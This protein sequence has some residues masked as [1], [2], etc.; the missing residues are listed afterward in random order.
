MIEHRPNC[1]VAPALRLRLVFLLSLVPVPPAAGAAEAVPMREH[2]RPGYQYHVSCRVDISGSLSLP[3]DKGQAAPK[4]LTVAGGSAIEYDE[5]ILQQDRD[6]VVK[7]TARLYRR[8]DFK[9]RVGDKLQESTIRPEVRRLVVLRHNNIEVPFSPDGPLLWGEMD[10]V[11]TD[12][13]TPALAGLFATQAVRP[14]AAWPA[15]RSAIQELTDMERIK[16]GSVTC[17]FEEFTTLSG[18]RHAR[19]G[20]R[21]TV[22]GVN[23]DGPNRQQLDGYFFFDLETNHLSYLYLKGTQFLL[24][25]D[26]KTQGKVVGHFTLTRQLNPH[27]RELSD[28]GLR[29]VKLDPDADNTLMLYDNPEIGV[30]FLF[31]RRWRVA[32][33]RGLQVAL[34]EINGNGLL[35]TLEPAAR[36]PTAA[37]FLAETRAWMGQQKAKVLRVEAPRRLQAAPRAV[38]QFAIDAEVMRERVLMDYY[39]LSQARGGATGTARLLPKDVA[40]VRKEVE[41]I[42]RSVEITRPIVAAAP[43]K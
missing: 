15:A 24:D 19:V 43:K 27:G 37:Q 3:A 7:K 18:H 21:G 2:F 17:K 38:D 41:K 14:G 23:E 9:R 6:G 25:G 5:R 26:G 42:V 34:D 8:I 4:S 16:S 39:V 10:L 29:G 40:A 22:E 20:F 35:L 31:P 12:V 11:R 33:V 1:P 32:G 13:F 30:R 36:V 28:G